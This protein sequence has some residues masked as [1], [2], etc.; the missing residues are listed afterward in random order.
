MSAPRNVT[1]PLAPEVAAF[2][3]DHAT[4]Q[5]KSVSALLA[6]VLTELASRLA[7]R[8]GQT[9]PTTPPPTRAPINSPLRRSRSVSLVTVPLPV[10]LDEILRARA[11]AARIPAYATF[12][13]AKLA[14]CVSFDLSAL[15]DNR[16]PSEKRRDTIAARKAAY[17]AARADT[18]PTTP[19]PPVH[20]PRQ[21]RPDRA[22]L[23][24]VTADDVPLGGL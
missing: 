18:Q 14:E 17:K 16:T 21:P 10:E 9:L 11:A 22:P 23:P 3:R 24:D 8:T 2:L 13:R 6:P 19:T 4:K 20:E 12:L 1:V 5:G 7:T 15:A